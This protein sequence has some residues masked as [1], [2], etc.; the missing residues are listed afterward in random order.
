[1]ATPGNKRYYPEV[2]VQR[3]QRN[4]YI[5]VQEWNWSIRFDSK[6]QRR[7]ELS[8]VMEQEVS[9]GRGSDRRVKSVN[10][11]TRH[12][13]TPTSPIPVSIDTLLWF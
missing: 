4:G 12:D 13:F 6:N 9:V 7:L 5:Y 10:T 11:E 2:V 3:I 1:M 8:L